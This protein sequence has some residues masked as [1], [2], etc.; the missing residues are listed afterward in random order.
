MRPSIPGASIH[1]APSNCYVE[2]IPCNRIDDIWPLIFPLVDKAVGATNGR[3]T[4]EDVRQHCKAG[5]MR[6]LVASEETGPVA[7]C[8]LQLVKFPRK[9]YC[10]LVL[11]GGRLAPWVDSLDTLKAWARSNGC[12][13]MMAI[14]RRGWKAVL[15][16]WRET[17]VMLEIDL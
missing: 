1:A 16:D 12:H 10:E 17:A 13:S 8:C 11:L 4:I 5:K 3:W 2:E 6:L 7:I 14:G 9:T 15:P